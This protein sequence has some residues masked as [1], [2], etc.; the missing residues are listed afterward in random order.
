MN[1][2]ADSPNYNRFNSEDARY[3]FEATRAREGRQNVVVNV[4]CERVIGNDLQLGIPELLNMGYCATSRTACI[5][6]RW[7]IAR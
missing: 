6:N 1:A 4:S 7:L 3:R 5:K 2:L